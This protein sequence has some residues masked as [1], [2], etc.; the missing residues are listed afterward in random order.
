M[1]Q[2]NLDR[3]GALNFSTI[4]LFAGA[5]ILTA[6]TIIMSSKIGEGGWNEFMLKLDEMLMLIR[7]LPNKWLMLIA[8][9]FVFLLKNFIPIPFPFIFVMSGILF[10]S[11]KAVAINIVGFS[12]VLMTKYWWGRKFGGGTA[13]K[14]LQK[15]D[16]VREMMYRPGN[17]KLGVLVAL[18][19][20]PSI[21]V[22]MVSK[23]YGGMKFPAGRFLIASVIGFLPKIWTYSVVGGNVSQP[24]TWHFM[25]PIVALFILSGTVTL[26][27]NIV[28]EKTK[29]SHKNV[30]SI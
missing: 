21:P 28:L 12:I 15:Y 3:K 23:I 6:I 14:Q 13:I 18:R 19:L 2:K 22:N 27:V 29:G 11:Y 7:G 20:I 24:F 26:I 4:C 10:D 9:L 8:I 30:E 16:N 17:A 1:E 5:A 25:G